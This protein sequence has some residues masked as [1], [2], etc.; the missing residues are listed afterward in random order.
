MKLCLDAFWRACLYCFYPQV[1]LMGL[2][3]VLLAG[4]GALVLGWFFWEPA[5]DAVRLGL[6]QSALLAPAMLWLDGI[7]NGA[8]RTVLGPLVVVA[9]SIP[10]LL[11]T[12]LLLVMA[13]MM[14]A[15]VGLVARRRFPDLE[16][17]R[18]GRWWQSLALSLGSTLLALA[19][20]VLSLPLWLL[21]PLALL[22]PPLIWGWLTARLLAWD[23]L[24]DHA[25]AEESRRLRRRHRGPLLA[26][27]VLTGYLG[28]AP[29]LVW[30]GGVVALPMMPLLVPVFAWVYT[31]VFAFAAL[32]FAHYTLAAL[33]AQ[34]AMDAGDA[35]V[36]EGVAA[37]VAPVEP[38]TRLPAA[39]PPAA[40]L[41]AL[42]E[43]PQA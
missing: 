17:R 14:P 15:L 34:R 20:L 24:A 32:W 22:L 19:V 12:S 35:A 37:P 41:Q 28:G 5:V 31:M 9:L 25:T 13:F 6:E 3:P 40:P 18:G 30:V 21:P 23:A 29:S 33:A 42:P 1:W 2:L 8:F 4:G 36:V 26:M 38:A 11:I 39:A 10:V 7:S 27:G 16:A 43:P